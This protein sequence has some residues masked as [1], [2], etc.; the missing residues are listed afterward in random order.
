M[1]E[2]R[3]ATPR[4]FS[5]ATYGGHVAAIAAAMG[6][7]LIPAQ[8][9]IADTALEVDDEGRFVYGKVIVSTQ[10]QVGKTELGQ[11]V[12]YQNALMG[13]RRRVWSTAQTGQD[14]AE[15]W[16][17][18]AE[19]LDESPLVRP[20]AKKSSRGIRLSNGSEA[21]TWRN[22]STVRPHP[23]TREKLHG[24][25]GDLN[26]VDEC[27]AFTQDQ[28]LALVQA[29]G[30]TQTT[31]SMVT[32]QNPMTWF[33]SAEGTIE[34]TWWNPMI[35]EAR[36]SPSAGTAIFDFG[37]R[38]GEDPM[39]LDVVAARHP[40]FG[41]LCDMRTLVYQRDE[42]FKGAPSE[43]ARAFGNVRTGATERAI[44][45]EPWALAAWHDE[46]PAGRPCFGAAVGL[47]GVDTTI[48]VTVPMH[49][50]K[51]TKV[52][53]DGWALGDGWA[54]DRMKDLQTKH[55]V[56]F[57]IDTRGPSA[58]LADAARR[59][60]LQLLEVNTGAVGVA[61]AATYAGIIAPDGPSW[62][63]V[64]HP[65]LDSAAE[66]ATWRYFGDGARVFGRRAS[67]GSISALEAGSLSAWGVDHLPE[68]VGI[69]LF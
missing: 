23:P 6:R 27:W 56:P 57:A 63:Y 39:D 64:P 12:G 9:Y 55:G 25:Q 16:R 61:H 69:Q 49:G 45:V 1:I 11:M 54:L 35:D 4:D 24:K 41:F 31:R 38:E 51:V 44:P 17:E 22:G 66:L 5:R 47:D 36:E 46:M 58:G 50:A 65:A 62:F 10:R 18:T 34:S 33:I 26:A 19:L 7:P 15:K 67:V 2:P 13:P 29:I 48:T 28:G 14:A 20:M 21:I 3:N 32:G 68:E 53:R 30:G 52:V 60:G 40:G 8:R 59:A 42:L 37:L 43:F